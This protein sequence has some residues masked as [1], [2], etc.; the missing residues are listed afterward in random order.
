MVASIVESLVPNFVTTIF[1][2][3]F[4]G[5]HKTIRITEGDNELIYRITSYKCQIYA[6]IVGNCRMCFPLRITFLYIVSN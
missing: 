6:L 2:F 4:T 5:R 1:E 3:S